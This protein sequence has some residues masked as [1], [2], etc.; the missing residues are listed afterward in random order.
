MN[1]NVSIIVEQTIEDVWL[2]W[3]DAY[4]MQKWFFTSPDWLCSKASSNFE[5]GGEF[6][7]LFIEKYGTIKFAFTGTYTK[8]IPHQFIEYFTEDGRQVSTY[9]IQDENGISITQEI[10]AEPSNTLENQSND[11]QFIL[12]NFKEYAEGL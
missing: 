11:W 12:T 9:F 3:T 4:H 7:V 1:I 8:I 6:G 5:V 10:E 2:A